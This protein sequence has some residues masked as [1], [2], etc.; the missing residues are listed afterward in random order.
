MCL[1]PQ[2]TSFLHPDARNTR[3]L[4]RRRK[5]PETL[6]GSEKEACPGGELEELPMEMKVADVVS[7]GWKF[8]GN[9][10]SLPSPDLI[11]VGRP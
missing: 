5:S 3:L 11:D 10:V 8:P 6:E 2:F 1:C 9:F 7:A 4:V